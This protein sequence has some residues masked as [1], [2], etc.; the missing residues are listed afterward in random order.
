MKPSPIIAEGQQLTI[1]SRAMEQGKEYPFTFLGTEMIAIKTVDIVDLYQNI[2]P[3]GSGRSTTLLQFTDKTGQPRT[4][5][6]IQEAI[7]AMQEVLVK[8]SLVLPTVTVHTGIIIDALRE[9]LVLRNLQV[10]RHLDKSHQ[11]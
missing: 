7:S 4:D 3:Y 1:N 5:R 11:V 10:K 2:G 9:L 6:E 8:H